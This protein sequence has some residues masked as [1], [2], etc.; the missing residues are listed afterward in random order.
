[1]RTGHAADQSIYDGIAASDYGHPVAQSDF[2][3]YLRDDVLTYLK[4]NCAEGDA[5]A[6]FFLHII[7]T[8]LSNLPSES[9]ERGFANLDFRFAEHGAYASD[10]CAAER[11][12]PN[13]PIDSIRTGQKATEVSGDGWRADINLAAR[14]AAQAIYDSIAAGDYGQ[15]LAQSDFAIFLRDALAYLKEYCETGDTDARFFL[16]IIPANPTDLPA[17]RRERGFANLYFHFT[18]HGADIG[19]KCVALRDLP[20][21]EIERIRTGQFVSGEGQLW[22]AEF[23]VRR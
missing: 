11:E 13:Y 9:R 15:P 21:Y 1:M 20:G 23:P 6:R 18:D 10:I 19:G 7:P 8:D 17:D 4:E 14:A 5:D 22:G 3:V 12:L 16:H 2:D